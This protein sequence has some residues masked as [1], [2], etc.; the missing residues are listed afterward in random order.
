MRRAADRPS[1]PTTPVTSPAGMPSP[2]IPAA[3]APTRGHAGQHLRGGCHGGEGLVRLLASHELGRG[4]TL[5]KSLL[6]RVGISAFPSQQERASHGQHPSPCANEEVGGYPQAGAHGRSSQPSHSR[7]P[8]TRGL[9]QP[10]QG[11]QRQCSLRSRL[12]RR[13]PRC[14]RS[15]ISCC[16][17]MSR[18][19]GANCRLRGDGR[20]RGHGH[21]VHAGCRSVLL[22]GDL[23]RGSRRLGLQVAGKRDEALDGSHATSISRVSKPTCCQDVKSHPPPPHRGFPWTGSRPSPPSP[24]HPPTGAS[25]GPA[26]GHPHPRPVATTTMQERRHCARTFHRVQEEASPDRIP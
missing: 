17:R 26:P 8:V 9:Q 1:P 21:R 2:T 7:H 3:M 20:P 10:A 14:R 12:A 18:R 24:T 6:R 5:G 13:P 19:P 25:L 4:H 22:H 16:P 23:R 11:P 15:H